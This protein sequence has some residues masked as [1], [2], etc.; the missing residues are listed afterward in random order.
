MQGNAKGMA[1]VPNATA[2]NIP[3]TLH[4]KSCLGLESKVSGRNTRP[5]LG[6]LALGAIRLSLT[7]NLQHV[8]ETIRR[9]PRTAR[10]GREDNDRQAGSKYRLRLTMDQAYC[11]GSRKQK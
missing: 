4:L 5:P 7:C 8:L 3:Q 2:S 9:S 10:K 6:T 11:S 1:K